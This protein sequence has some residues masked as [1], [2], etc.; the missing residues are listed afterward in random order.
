MRTYRDL[1]AVP[2]APAFV[3]AGFVARLPVA[4]RG[5]GCLLLV[6]ATTGSY[7]LAGAV[8]AALMLSQAAAAPFLGRAA[9][10]HGQRRMLLATLLV[11]QAGMVTLLVA[12]RLGLPAWTLIAAAVLAGCATIPIGPLVRSRWAA[13]VGDS[14]RLPGAY[15]LESVIDEII[16][17]L[18]PILVTVLAVHL[19]P[20]AGLL[21]ALVLVTT[22]TV[23]LA[24]ARGTEPPRIPRTDRPG[25]GPLR[26]R[27]ML[28]LSLVFLLFGT[29]LG[30]IDVGVIAFAE[31]QGAPGWAGVLLAL[32]A[33]GSMV[34]GLAWGGVGV[35]R[36]SEPARFVLCGAAVGA[37][38]LPLLF[39]DSL[40]ALALCMVLAGSAVAPLLIT[41]STL[42]QTLL[43]RQ[44]LTEGFAWMYSAVTVGMA[45]G[46]AL[47]GALTDSRGSEGALLLAVTTGLAT[48]LATAAGRP[49]LTPPARPSAPVHPAPARRATPAPDT[50]H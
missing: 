26:T 42:V 14:G 13:L 31:E 1:L 28:L 11:H 15:A 27:G 47:G 46:S 45:S 29:F 33:L 25:R 36:L 40:T 8:A 6:S 41:G 37:T 23:A 5:L 43:P 7:A 35:W 20:E 19:F 48:A 34:A 2:G 16:Y 24:A 4:M 17:V 12:S 50:P 39:I 21:G 9:D 18:G 3:T 10:R 44:V 32:L 49:R 38:S 30:A 22:G